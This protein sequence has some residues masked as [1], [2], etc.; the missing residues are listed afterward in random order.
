MMRL[1]ILALGPS[2]RLT[3]S[4]SLRAMP[5]SCPRLPM[6]K[7]FGSQP[8]KGVV[9]GLYQGQLRIEG[10]PGIFDFGGGLLVFGLSVFGRAVA[11]PLPLRF[12]PDRGRRLFYGPGLLSFRHR[13][14]RHFQRHPEDGHQAAD[15]RPRGWA[16]SQRRIGGTTFLS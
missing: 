4:T 2:R 8:C 15:R 1:T 16:A 9:S 10:G 14:R 6:K 5:V 12:E 13:R 7:G 3:I 11:G